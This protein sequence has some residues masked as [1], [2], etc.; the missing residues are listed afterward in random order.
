MATDNLGDKKA[1]EII[2][3]TFSVGMKKT[4][5]SGRSENVVILFISKGFY[6]DS[7]EIIAVNFEWSKN[8]K[9]TNTGY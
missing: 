1:C 8:W 2:R 5:F 6:W 4:E 9:W 3:T 7:N